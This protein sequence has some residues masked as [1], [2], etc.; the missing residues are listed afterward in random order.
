MNKTYRK[1]LLRGVKSSLSR[2][3]SILGIVFIGTGFLAG[4]LATAPDMEDTADRYYDDCA[5]LDADIKGTLGVTD[6]DIAILSN[7]PGVGTAMPASVTD[8]VLSLPDGTGYVA[9]LYG[10]P[11]EKRGTEAFLNDFVLNGGRLPKAACECVLVCPSEFHETCGIGDQLTISPENEHYE[12]R[13]DTYALDT[14]T[15]VGTAE[16]PYHMSIETE[17]S[18]VGAGSIEFF[19]IAD[20]SCYSLD[21]Y[22]DAFVTL[23]GA[24]ALNA[25]SEEYENR[26][27]AFVSELETLGL[28][29]SEVRFAE[30]RGE[31][32]QEID[33]AQAEYDETA[34]DVRNDI[35]DA[36]K[37]LEDARTELADARQELTTAQGRYDYAH[38]KYYESK[39]AFERNIAKQRADAAEAERAGLITHDQ[40]HAAI[41]AIDRAEA[42]GQKE[43]KTAHGKLQTAKDQIADG[44]RELADAETEFA[45]AERELAETEADAEQEL[46]DAQQKIDDAQTELDDLEPPEWKVL[47]RF[48]TVSFVSYESNAGKIGAIARVFPIFLFLVAALVALTTMTRMVEEE[49]TQIGTL[50]ALGYTDNAIMAYY[51]GYSMLASLIGCALGTVAGFRLIPTVISQAYTMMYRMPRIHTVYRHNIAWI[52]APIAIVCTTVATLIACRSELSRKPSVLMRPRAPKAGKR[53]FLERIGPLWKRLKF[54]Q[55][56]TCRNMF[57]YKKRLYMTVFGIAGCMALLLTGFGLYDS[58]N[59]IVNRQF[60]ELYRYDTNIYLDSGS[61]LETN[62][63]LTARLNDPAVFSDHLAVH[64]ENGEMFS[65]LSSDS[66]NIYVPQETDGLKRLIVLRERRSGADIPFDDDTVVLTEKLCETLNLGIGD[67]F[68]LVNDS[69]ASATFTVTGITENYVA[70]YVFISSSAYQTAFV[71]TPAFDRVIAA[72]ADPSPATRDA[73]TRQLLSDDDVTLVQYNDSIRETFDNMVGNV[74]YIVY[75]LIAGAGALALIVLYNLTNINIS[76][77]KK[78]LATIKV[79]GFYEREVGNYIFRETN[80]LSLL[81][82]VFGCGFGLWLHAFVI[83]TAEVDGIMF[84]RTLYPR[85]FLLAAAVTMLFT[86]MVDALMLPRIRSIDMVES[87][88]A[89]D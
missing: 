3:L 20:L 54:T 49:R 28:P 48:D 30:V 43:L 22:T 81:G 63:T 13:A 57:R 5:I 67:S 64:A 41:A 53:I 69:D 2:F 72:L 77:R 8:L 44:E 78:E 24:S 88:K 9:R 65:A 79:L 34:A 16:T 52:I 60:G 27:D 1:L 33:D 10:L 62:A 29:R 6:D 55:K 73:V 4:L 89:N 35:A 36:H 59:D 84:G 56:V 14:F 40:Y 46:A 58:I 11:L 12:D 82:T 37:E 38:Y 21:V 19:L 68:T 47:S 31:A 75:V 80:L 7:L 85:S 66:V 17:P 42:D 71:G 86:F 18:G 23:A 70:N 76:E 45:D 39:Y 51:L 25:F 50:K 15:I 61:V 87:M 32:Q 83:R 26:V 74:N